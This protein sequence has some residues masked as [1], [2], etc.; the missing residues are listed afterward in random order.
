MPTPDI[1]FDKAHYF[2]SNGISRRRKTYRLYRFKIINTLMQ[3]MSVL[4]GSTDLEFSSMI[5]I[6]SVIIH[7]NFSAGTLA[8]DIALIKVI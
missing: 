6:E 2:L 8:N 5:G 3:Y 1:L 7:E 4:Y